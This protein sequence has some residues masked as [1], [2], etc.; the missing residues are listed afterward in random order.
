MLFLQVPGGPGG[1]GGNAG[2]FKL[3]IVD[4]IERI[5]EEFNFLQA[6]YHKYADI[7]ATVSLRFCR[8]LPRF[9]RFSLDCCCCLRKCTANVSLPW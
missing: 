9:L 7:E 8:G 1:P 6:Q 2:P 5:K 4:S 3:N